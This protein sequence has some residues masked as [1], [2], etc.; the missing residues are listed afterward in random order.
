M[1]FTDTEIEIMLNIQYDESFLE[2]SYRSKDTVL[3]QKDDGEHEHRFFEWENLFINSG[4]SLR[5]E[6]FI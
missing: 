1:K 3:L 2:K 4:L 5:I 6:L